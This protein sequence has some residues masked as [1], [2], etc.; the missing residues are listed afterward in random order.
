MH[1]SHLGFDHHIG[2][3]FLCSVGLSKVGNSRNLSATVV[4][5]AEWDKIH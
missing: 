5:K 2:V 3:Q 1:H 4:V